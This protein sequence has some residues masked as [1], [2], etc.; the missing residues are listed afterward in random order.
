MNTHDL[1]ALYNAPAAD[2]DPTSPRD[3]LRNAASLLRPINDWITSELALWLADT[4]I[5]H[6][7]DEHGTNCARDDDTWPC[8]DIKAARKV[9]EAIRLTTPETPRA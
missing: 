9:A 2:I 7:P 4:A 5:I 8:L 3:E 1:E 6:A